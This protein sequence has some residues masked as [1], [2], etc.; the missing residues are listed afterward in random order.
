MLEAATGMVVRWD[1]FGEFSSGCKLRLL[2]WF[3]HTGKVA[4]LAGQTIAGI[5]WAIACVMVATGFALS[6]RRLTAWRRRRRVEAV[7][8][9]AA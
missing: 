5:A 2:L 9:Q 7:L 8:E 6:W 4:G 3:A 1:P